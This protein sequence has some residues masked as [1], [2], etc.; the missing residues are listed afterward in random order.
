MEKYLG[1]LSGPLLDRIDLYAEVPPLD[2]DELSR[3]PAA[4][5]SAVIRARVEAARAVQAARFGPDGPS[6]NAQ[7]GPAEL[8]AYCAL[9]ADGQAVMKGAFQRM[10]LTARSYDRILRVARHHRRSGRARRTSAWSTWPRPS[11]TG[12]APICADRVGLDKNTQI[13][14][15]NETFGKESDAR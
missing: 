3:R 11:S 13:G 14:Y 6:C 1:K 10:G 8:A 5:P 12:R 4:E 7:M 15:N 9:D 2:F